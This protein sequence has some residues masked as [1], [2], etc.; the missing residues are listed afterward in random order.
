MRENLKAARK[1]KGMTQAQAATKLGVT[2]R[3]YRFIE[4]G[5]RNGDFELWDTLEDLFGVHQR[6]LREDTGRQ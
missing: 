3:Y 5:E 6:T 1:A 4:S 2:E